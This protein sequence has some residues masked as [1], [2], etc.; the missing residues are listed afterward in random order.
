L[1]LPQSSLRSGTFL[2]RHDEDSAEE[3]EDD[4]NDHRGSSNERTNGGFAGR[5]GM[6]GSRGMSMDRQSP[7]EGDMEWEANDMEM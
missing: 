1:G 2:E 5:A 6:N 4:D 7:D 3:D